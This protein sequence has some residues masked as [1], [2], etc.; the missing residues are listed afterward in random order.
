[1]WLVKL[2][3]HIISG[4]IILLEK[5]LG[6][7]NRKAISN[8][9]LIGTSSMD[10]MEGHVFEWYCANLLE[11]NGFSH[12]EVTRGSGD[13]GVDIL[14]EKNGISYAIQCKRFSG[15]VGN[16]AVQEAFSG[17]AFYG[18]SHAIVMTNS[19]FTPQAINAADRLNVDLWDR[20]V[21][22]QLKGS[23]SRVSAPSQRE[24]KK[25]KFGILLVIAV[26]ALIIIKIPLSKKENENTAETVQQD[27][28]TISMR[29]TNQSVNNQPSSQPTNL[30]L[31]LLEEPPA[32]ADKAGIIA[33][34]VTVENENAL[35]SDSTIKIVAVDNICYIR[36]DNHLE[37][38]GLK[39]SNK[40]IVKI[41]ESIDGVPVTII[42]ER[43]FEEED[44]IMSVRLPA[45]I[46][47]IGAG[48]FS[49]CKN[50]ISINIPEGVISIEDQAFILC[51]SLSKIQL[52]KS[53]VSIGSACFSMTAIENI[54]L[55]NVLSI[56]SNAFEGCKKLVSV[57]L[58]AELKE[59]PDR[60]FADCNSLR[61][62]IIYEGIKSIGKECF[63]GC[64]SL[65]SIKLPDSLSAIGTGCFSWCSSLA[66]VKIPTN[67]S[68]IT[69]P[70]MF[71][72][73]QSLKNI[74]VPQG[75]IIPNEGK[76]SSCEAEI[77]F[78]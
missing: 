9:M 56:G 40:S 47:T 53:I 52:P 4:L 25:N 2:P 18:R 42:R 70:Q 63:M 29:D 30:P 59:L 26:I 55:N 22:T 65:Y 66:E 20:D 58:S 46:T 14:A 33:Q 48:A 6:S 57:T 34:A 43:A 74:Y 10:S 68:E 12:V 49:T 35:W 24:Y 23:A 27:N 39:D 78:Y 51:Q 37:V 38:V 32:E 71:C 64:S 8:N 1:M 60:C 73:T 16:K 28:G 54:L 72:H 36:E 41:R 17:A 31:V 21:L 61:K 5:L 13:N 50:L 69:D 75:C 3:L 62:V 15:K 19:Y 45:T 7:S 11:Q 76:F 44:G 77:I 67:V